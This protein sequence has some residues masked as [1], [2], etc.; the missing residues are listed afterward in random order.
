MNPTTPHPAA[1]RIVRDAE[2]DALTGVSRTTRHNWRKE[3]KFPSP[4]R[5]G[6]RAVGYTLSSIMRWIED[7]AAASKKGGAK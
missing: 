5:L 3:G 6:P 2:L 7:C 4:I 1:D